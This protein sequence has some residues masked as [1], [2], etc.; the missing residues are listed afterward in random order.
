MVAVIP[1]S[2]FPAL[3]ND[4]YGV[5]HEDAHFAVNYVHSKIPGCDKIKK[6]QLRQ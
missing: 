4:L 2:P 1:I 5:E 6:H 3:S